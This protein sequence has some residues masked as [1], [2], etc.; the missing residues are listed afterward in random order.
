MKSYYRPGTFWLVLLATLLLGACSW[1]PARKSV[2][3]S[4]SSS[5]ASQSG[6]RA[7]L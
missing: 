6:F 7:T 5:Q 4:Q 1:S 3:G 2:E